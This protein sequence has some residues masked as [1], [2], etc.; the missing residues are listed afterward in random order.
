ME[1]LKSTAGK[2]IS[3][4]VALAV[5]AGGISWWRMDE[6]TRQLRAEASNGHAA[7]YAQTVRRLFGLA[8]GSTSCTTT[9]SI[10]TD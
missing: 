5:V 7:E 3:G 6:P 8:T 1:F 10:D 9:T 4:L 2:I